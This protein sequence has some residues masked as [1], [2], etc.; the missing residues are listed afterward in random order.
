MS[1]GNVNGGDDNYWMSRALELAGMARDQDEVP[2]GALVVVDGKLLG[3]GHN[4]MISSA[5]PTAHAEINALRQAAQKLHNYRLVGATLYSTIEPCTMCAGAMIHARINRLVY[6]A[7]EPR[8]GAIA[9]TIQALANKNLNHRIEVKAGVMEDACS[10][11]I[12]QY[13]KAKR[14]H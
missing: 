3:E 7:S 8:A 5:D 2:V 13:F 9:S 6:G 4:Q 1:P 12:T 11:I 10:Q 14:R